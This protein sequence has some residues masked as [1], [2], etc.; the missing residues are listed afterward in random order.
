MTLLDARE[1][2]L[3]WFLENEGFEPAVDFDNFLDKVSMTRDE[4]KELY[5]AALDELSE[6]GFLVKLTVRGKPLWKLTKP[7]RMRSQN[8]ELSYPV[9][10]A[11][12]STI[13][14]F[15][16]A[17][18]GRVARVESFNI[19]EREIAILVD[20]IATLSSAIAEQ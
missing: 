18:D 20:I 9:I 1:N 5:L 14:D 6:N 10:S 17:T 19:G 12:T 13:N 4:D 3:E 8:V 16:A 15:S 2:L 7:L 11:I